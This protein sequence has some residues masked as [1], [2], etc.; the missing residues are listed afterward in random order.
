MRTV[1]FDLD[2]TLTDTLP[3]VVAALNAALAPVWGAPRSP[4]EIR[5][6]FG[7]AE[8]PLIAAQAPHDPQAVER[9]YSYYRDHHQRAAKVFPGVRPMLSTLA[10]RG[11]PLGLVT[12]K[13]RRSALITLEAFGLR[14]FFRVIVDGEEVALPKPAPDSIR[15]ALARL[16]ADAGAACYVGDMESDLAA[17]RA[18]GV[19]GW[20][21]A[22]SRPDAK[23]EGWDFVAR[24]PDDVLHRWLHQAAPV[25]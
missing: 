5:S 7:P 16:G 13:G 12:N 14:R 23:F 15:L 8:G 3:L 20:A 18:A 6:L 24:H 4:D 25:T 10:E 21:A 22:W 1:L 17:A 2:G 11:C 9:F 19:E